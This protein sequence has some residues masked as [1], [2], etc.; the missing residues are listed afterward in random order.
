MSTPQLRSDNEPV[1]PEPDDQKEPL[2]ANIFDFIGGMNAQLSPLFPYLEP[3]AIVPC[4]AVFKGAAGMGQGVGNFQHYND[5]T[6]NAF[7]FGA[8]GAYMKTGMA[9]IGPNQHAVGSML[10]DPSDENSYCV[11]TVTQRQ[12]ETGTQ[13]EAF[14]LFCD[15]CNTEIFRHSYDVTPRQGEG[16][17]THPSPTFPTIV[18]GMAGVG[19]FNS[20]DENRVC[21]KCGHENA[22]FPGEHWGREYAAQ[23]SS[24]ELG[25]AALTNEGQR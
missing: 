8:H 24:A 12:K 25:H 13:E 19:R 1:I 17:G 14:I 11:M 2:Q 23:K 5:V 7:C 16:V 21:K 6:E 15:N 9:R 10:A 3:G 18:Q 4:G 20:V 22:K